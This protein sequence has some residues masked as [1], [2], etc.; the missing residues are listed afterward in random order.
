MSNTTSAM[1]SCYSQPVTR[2]VSLT[3]LTPNVSFTTSQC[4]SQCTLP[5]ERADEDPSSQHTHTHARAHAVQTERLR[6]FPRNTHALRRAGG[7]GC[8]HCVCA[9]L[10]NWLP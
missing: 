3:R 7:A 2:H 8:L 4:H 10:P 1:R 5:R 9:I 6:C